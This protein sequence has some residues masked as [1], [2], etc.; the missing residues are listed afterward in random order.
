MDDDDDW[1]QPSKMPKAEPTAADTSRT[2]V[3]GD[4]QK[5]ARTNVDVDRATASS[6]WS[7]AHSTAGSARQKNKQYTLD[8][9]PRLDATSL[10]YECG[11]DL[12][13]Q[14]VSLSLRDISGMVAAGESGMGEITNMLFMTVLMAR[15]AG[16]FV[17][18]IDCKDNTYLDGY[19]PVFTTLVHRSQGLDA[20][21]REVQAVK[22]L[23][24]TRSFLV[25]RLQPDGDYWKLNA[26]R[27]L[28]PL[29]LFIHECGSLF[30]P[31]PN[32]GYVSAEDLKTIETIKQLLLQIVERGTQAGVIVVL[33][34]QQPS[35]E[36]LP[37]LL[38]DACQMRLCFG[39]VENNVATAIFGDRFAINDNPTSKLERSHAVISTPNGT[40]PNV[41]FYTVAK[42]VLDQLIGAAQA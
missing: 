3:P 5:A 22:R 8:Q 16:V 13:M 2:R 19:K 4:S 30:H 33:S 34:T 21:L 35:H 36:S 14:P 20:L 29:M 6:T 42:P 1:V 17:R 12:N 24:N 15:R 9:A 28:K 41:R 25:R 26:E 10:G 38:V 23:V 18:F 27:R 39:A 37:E 11:L 32:E 40:I 7:T 31:D